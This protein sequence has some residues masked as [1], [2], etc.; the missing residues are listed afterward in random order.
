MIQ[1]FKL[2]CY[3]KKVHLLMNYIAIDYLV[4]PLSVYAW[5]NESK[6]R[7]LL[8]ITGWRGDKRGE[9]VI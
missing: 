6:E 1:L 9:I 4:S 5:S 7:S 2:L 3:N 8:C